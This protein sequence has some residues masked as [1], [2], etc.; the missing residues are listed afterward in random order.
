MDG[1]GSVDGV[2]VGGSDVSFEELTVSST[3]DLIV[4]STALA[5]LV[6]VGKRVLKRFTDLRN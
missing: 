1:R 3:N 6:M 2:Y 5:N 4:P